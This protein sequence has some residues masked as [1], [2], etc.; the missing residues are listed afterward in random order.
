[1][2]FESVVSKKFLP[3]FVVALCIVSSICPAFAVTDAEYSDL[4]SRYNLLV[5]SNSALQ[6]DMDILQEQYDT[7]NQQYTTLQEQY[8]TL[9]TQGYSTSGLDGAT[10]QDD[11]SMSGIISAIFGTYSPKTQTVTQTLDNGTVVTSQEI[12]PG[13]AGMDWHWIAGV[14]LFTVVLWSFFRFLGVIF[15]HG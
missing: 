4:S 3:F 9:Q 8:S 5:Q 15:K 11:N 12:I 10:E 14:L 13:V 1:M 7:L 2:N 6:D